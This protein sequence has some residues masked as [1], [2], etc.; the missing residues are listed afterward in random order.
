MLCSVCLETFETALESVDSG[1]GRFLS[2]CFLAGG[3]ND[4]DEDELDE[5][6]LES[7]ELDELDELDFNFFD[8]LSE[9]EDDLVG[10]EAV[11]FA[12]ALDLAAG[13]SDSESES[14]ELLN[15][16]WLDE[17][18]FL[19]A[20]VAFAIGLAAG[21]ATSELEDDD[22]EESLESEDDDEEEDELDDDEEV[23]T[24]DVFLVE[25]LVETARVV[26]LDPDFEVL[27]SVD[28]SCF[29]FPLGLLSTSILEEAGAELEE[30]ESD[31]ELESEESEEEVEIFFEV[32]FLDFSAV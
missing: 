5:E 1:A 2:S 29:D 14:D 31:E 28:A 3:G 9:V 26:G 15:E 6:S 20:L 32:L 24:L 30:L 18:T 16:L 23:V 8:F 17:D 10:V 19:A 12:L 11:A 7:L 25:G 21:F 22:D 13:A 4:A 27:D